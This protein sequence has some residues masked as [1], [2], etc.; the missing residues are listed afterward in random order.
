MGHFGHF[1]QIAVSRHLLGHLA[2]SG[3]LLGVLGLLAK[4]VSGRQGKM[5]FFLCAGPTAFLGKVKFSLK[6]P[7]FFGEIFGWFQKWPLKNR[8]S[9]FFLPGDFFLGH[10]QNGPLYIP[11]K[12]HLFWGINFWGILGPKMGGHSGVAF[13]PRSIRSRVW[14][15]ALFGHF[16]EPKSFKKCSREP[17]RFFRLFGRFLGGPDFF[18]RS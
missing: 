11:K 17:G 7:R 16:L 5:H 3:T 14:V 13:W 8:G 18:G 6:V 10:F 9:G 2:L 1:G 15:L 4:K 12:P